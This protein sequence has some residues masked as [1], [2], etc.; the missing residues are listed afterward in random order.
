MR[1]SLQN[2]WAILAALIIAGVA[3][4]WYMSKES[5]LAWWHVVGMGLTVLLL[6]LIW[7]WPGTKQPK[8]PPL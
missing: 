4:S 8:G 5:G 1:G 6:A 3:I 7:I 2:V